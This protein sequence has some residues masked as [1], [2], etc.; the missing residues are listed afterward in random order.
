MNRLSCH[1]RQQEKPSLDTFRIKP[2]WW[3][4]AMLATANV[5]WDCHLTRA[6]WAI[7]DLCL[8]LQKKTGGKAV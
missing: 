4:R 7:A 6:S 8:W 1:N 5:L 3:Q 2:R